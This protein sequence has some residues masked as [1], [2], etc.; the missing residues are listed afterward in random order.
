MY[1]LESELMSP[2]EARE[3]TSLGEHTIAYVVPGHYVVAVAPVGVYQVA[4]TP[5]GAATRRLDDG[6]WYAARTAYFE[7]VRAGD[8][9][10]LATEEAAFSAAT[11]A[12]SPAEACLES[13]E[14]ALESAVYT[15]RD[16]IDLL[17]AS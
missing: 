1:Y 10:R 15:Y 14:R 16:A 13:A 11:R 17:L 9:L 8:A 6:A 12:T 2:H 7:V 4:H 5:T 3:V